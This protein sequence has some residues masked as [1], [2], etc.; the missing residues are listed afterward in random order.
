MSTNSFKV[1]LVRPCKTAE[2]L[3]ALADLDGILSLRLYQIQSFENFGYL[4]RAFW[5]DVELT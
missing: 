2:V 1:N 3:H 4:H 5:V